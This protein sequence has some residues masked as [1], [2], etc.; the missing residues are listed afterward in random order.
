MTIDFKL[1]PRQQRFCLL[2]VE[3]ETQVKAYQLA[4][5]SVKGER[6]AAVNASK[7]LTNAN[8]QS[9]IAQQQAKAAERNVVTVESI[10]ANLERIS[11]KAEDAGS[12]GPAAIAQGMIAK[13]N[14]LMVDRS[15]VTVSH[16]PAP[17]PTKIL[18]LSEQDWVRQ[19]GH[20]LQEKRLE[21]LEALAR[22]K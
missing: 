9:F 18:E 5:Y 17:L 20:G 7:L 16:K 11:R 1:T 12:F 15:E 14:G 3:G 21:K 8:I 19:F 2:I 6:V 22:K 4:G 13:L 10:T